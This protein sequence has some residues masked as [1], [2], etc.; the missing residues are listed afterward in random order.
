MATYE[1][2]GATGSQSA[3]PHQALQS[4]QILPFTKVSH[5]PANPVSPQPNPS[6]QRGQTEA[7]GTASLGIFEFTML[8]VF[9]LGMLTGGFLAYV[10]VSFFAR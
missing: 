4:A 9:V 2:E 8:D 5:K 7:N 1:D 10:V 3:K 6:E